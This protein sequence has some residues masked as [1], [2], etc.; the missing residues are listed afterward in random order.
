MAELALRNTS[1][2]PKGMMRLPRGTDIRRNGSEEFLRSLGF[3]DIKT[4]DHFHVIARPP[5]GWH[6]DQRDQTSCW[7]QCLDAGGKVRFSIYVPTDPE[8][9]PLIQTT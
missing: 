8:E 2:I 1:S 9:E 6:I 7:M 4:E 3:T 5:V